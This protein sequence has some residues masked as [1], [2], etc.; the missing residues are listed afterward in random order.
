MRTLIAILVLLFI[1]LNVTAQEPDVKASTKN[2]VSTQE[3]ANIKML[4]VEVFS[5]KL[6]L[7]K[8]QIAKVEILNVEF[9][10]SSEKV[11]QKDYVDKLSEIL[12]DEQVARWKTVQKSPQRGIEEAPK[13]H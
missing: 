10:E 13:N 11:T 3:P 6:N 9:S 2:P 7:T 5:E 12:N 4:D 8:D 1:S